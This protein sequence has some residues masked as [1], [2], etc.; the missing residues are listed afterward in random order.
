M[1]KLA[2]LFSFPSPICKESSL[3]GPSN[4]QVISAP[5]KMRVLAG[6]RVQA[7]EGVSPALRSSVP[8]CCQC[9]SLSSLSLPS[10]APSLPPSLA[11]SFWGREVPAPW[12]E[13]QSTP[14]WL[15][16][17]GVSSMPSKFAKKPG[18]QDTLKPGK[19]VQFRKTSA[20][21]SCISHCGCSSTPSP[22]TS[23]NGVL[24]KYTA[25][26]LGSG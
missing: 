17:P 14:V 6:S 11:L 18:L 4:S 25:C 22:A 7:G 16:L 23:E 19:V 9:L 8:S 3:L 2:L 26:P 13:T 21:P 10:L 5:H 20:S 15:C 24:V 1:G 12:P